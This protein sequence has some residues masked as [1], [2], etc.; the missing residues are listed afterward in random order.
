[1]SD[2]QQILE[3][4]RSGKPIMTIAEETGRGRT[5]VTTILKRAGI[6]KKG[7]RGAPAK[8]GDEDIV[9]A[10]EAY[11]YGKSA[12]SVAKDMGV[13]PGMIRTWAQQRGFVKGSR[14][15]PEDEVQNIIAD[16]L[17]GA[18]L[19]ELSR[20]YNRTRTTIRRLLL[21]EGIRPVLQRRR[22]LTPEQEREIAADYAAGTIMQRLADKYSVS[23]STI[24]N[25]LD[26]TGT[27]AR[28]RG[29]AKPD[30][31]DGKMR[32]T[33]CGEYKVFSAFHPNK[34]HKSG[35]NHYCR[36]CARWKNVNN[37]GLTKE[38]YLRLKD[39]QQGRCA[40]CLRTAEEAGH[41][42][43]HPDLVVD[44]DHESGAVRGL[45]CVHCNQALGHLGDDMVRLT[46]AVAY[47]SRST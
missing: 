14:D 5:S 12:A 13:S 3:A 21:R 43:R 6:Y 27:S 16:S 31:I 10:V 28:G 47:L 34:K 22:I 40:I 1:M 25:T 30:I 26:S 4:Y 36:E 11:K 45:L 38:N 42:S 46:A 9:K 20:R 2:E 8:Y 7:K 39:Q 23:I 41:T 15:I 33:S 44:H 29:P 24:K 18:D 37:Y 17:G 35:K 32:C 19:G